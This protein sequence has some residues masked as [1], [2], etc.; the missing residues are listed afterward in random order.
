MSI[1][2]LLLRVSTN[3]LC[4]NCLYR[5][6]I[7]HAYPKAVESRKSVLTEEDQQLL[8]QFSN[9]KEIE[10]QATRVENR[11][12]PLEMRR[13]VQTLFL[14]FAIVVTVLVSAWCTF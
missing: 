13:V 14:F 3:E 4:T 1:L 12:V 2:L 9:A 11:H 8:K 10:S 5:N 7:E 6:I